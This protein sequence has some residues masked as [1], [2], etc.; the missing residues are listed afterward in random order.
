MIHFR[1]LELLQVLDV[2]VDVEM[3]H[4]LNLRDQN[5]DNES[6]GPLHSTKMP[7]SSPLQ[8]VSTLPRGAILGDEI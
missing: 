8:Q 3:L 5:Q 4:H 6:C 1:N 7:R 2:L